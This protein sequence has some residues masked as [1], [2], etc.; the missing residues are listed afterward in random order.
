VSRAAL[1]PLLAALALGCEASP[2]AAPPVD[3]GL[4]DVALDAPT[5]D[6]ASDVTPTGPLSARIEGAGFVYQGEETCLTVAHNGGPDA[7]F[8]WILEPDGVRASTGRACRRWSDLGAFR[9]FVTVESRGMRVEV[10][11]PLRVVARPTTPRPTAS[12]TIAYDPVRREVWVVN[13][14]AD[15]VTVL[16]DEPTTRLAEVPVCDHPR[17]LAVSGPTVAV[18]CQ[19]DGALWLLDAAGRSRRVAVAL[20][21]GAR[22]YGVAADPRGGR[23]FVTLQDA[24]RLVVVDATTGSVTGSVDVGF[25]AR[26]ITVNAAGTALV[27]R[28]RGDAEGARVVQVDASDPSSP[29]RVGV[30]LLQVQEDLDSDTDNSGVPSFLGALAFGPAGRDAVVPALKAN[31]VTGMFRTREMLSSQ[32]T[33]R[34]VLSVVSPGAAGAAPS[35]AA[36]YSFDDLDYASALAFSPQGDRLFVALQ[37][38]EIVVALDPEGFN[39]TGSIPSVGGAPEGLA[40]SPD[41]ARLFVQGFTTRT[42]RVYDVRDLSRA[43]T[44][45]ADVV[46]VAAEPLPS[47]VALGQRI[48]YASRDPRMSRT[49][50]LSCASCHLDG[51]GDN[52][53]WDFTQRGEGL[54]NTIPLQGRG[55][56]EHGPMH[57]SANFDEVQDFEHD[58]RGGQGG[59]GF[60]ADPVFHADGHDVPLGA[61]KLGLSSELDALSAY[62]ASLRRVGPSPFRRDGDAAWLAS[63]ARG[64]ALFR[65]EE[66]RCATCH[67]GPRYTDS[68]FAPGTRTPVLHDVGTLGPGSGQ[69]LGGPLSGLDTPTLRDLWRTAPYLHNGSAA[70]L[71]DVL[72]TRNRDDRH[73]RTSGLSTAQLSDLETFLLSVE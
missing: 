52:L 34:A 44:P 73:G 9:A 3:A 62:V 35:E 13:P 33:A 69:R 67:A 37:G 19:D 40:L 45:L 28:W 4:T 54:R 43:P 72:V 24:G 51:E 17:T 2:A 23:F 1:L 36:R 68:A 7:R 21:A 59:L 20:G 32:T 64:E 66:T 27:A 46:T 16:S 38:A 18:A 48:F 42:V 63:R 10:S 8:S 55:G 70:T 50:Y 58:I 41:G 12:S 56:V 39:I 6:A 61:S 22:P 25:D 5:L 11:A 53:V 15:S 31:N 71:R 60:V 49:S 30:G 29:R 47:Q 14:D 26:G 65:S 57:W